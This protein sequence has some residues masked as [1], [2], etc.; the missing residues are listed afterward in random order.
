[1]RRSRIENNSDNPFNDLIESVEDFLESETGNTR[2]LIKCLQTLRQGTPLSSEQQQYVDN[3]LRKPRKPLG[4]NSDYRKIRILNYL[5][6]HPDG[7]SKNKFLSLPNEPGITWEEIKLLLG[8][9][10][11]NNLVERKTSPVDDSV[12][13]IITDQGRVFLTR[14]IEFRNDCGINFKIF[15][16]LD[17]PT[18]A[19]TF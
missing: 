2:K 5:L 6:A 3:L 9:L 17:Q 19:D 10:R 12:Y 4:W 1:M 8:E 18:S 14:L 11:S 7:R 13:Y 15:T 16:A